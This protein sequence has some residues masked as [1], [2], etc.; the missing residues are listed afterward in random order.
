MG[1][2][3][4][5]HVDSKIYAFKEDNLS[6]GTRISQKH[7]VGTPFHISH[8]DSYIY[9]LEVFGMSLKQRFS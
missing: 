6:D 2:I 9:L 3:W 1:A 4:G 5:K 8:D 7:H